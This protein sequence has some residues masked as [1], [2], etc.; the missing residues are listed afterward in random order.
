MEKK[1]EREVLRLK[2]VYD[3]DP[4]V[5][6]QILYE[7]LRERPPEANISHREMPSY[8]VHAAFVASRPYKAWYLIQEWPMTYEEAVFDR[9]RPQWVGA[10]A[11]TRANEVAVA[12]FAAHQRKGYAHQAITLLQTMHPG[13]LLANVAPGNLRSHALFLKLGARVIQHTYQL[14][15]REKDHD[16]SQTEN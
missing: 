14:P 3:M 10:V 15:P 8:E 13:S 2:D 16:E 5:A 9:K 4:P 6:G 12:V 1:R 11:I 7:L